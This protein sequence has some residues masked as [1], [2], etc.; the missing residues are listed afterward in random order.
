MLNNCKKNHRAN[1][2][3]FGISA[4]DSRKSGDAITPGT[5]TVEVVP[6]TPPSILIMLVL[7]DVVR[8]EGIRT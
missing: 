8:I 7:K 4:V 2:C 1:F 6:K 5:R 3:V